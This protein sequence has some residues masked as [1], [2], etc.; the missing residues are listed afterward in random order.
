MSLSEEYEQDLKAFKES[1][2]T[3]TKNLWIEI[4]RR[5]LDY[6]AFTIY[7]ICDSCLD[8]DKVREVIE[9]LPL[10]ARDE[11]HGILVPILQLEKELGL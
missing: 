9:N 8:K 2:P 10:C 3:F 4:S 11:N 1:F 5:E 6:P 7:A